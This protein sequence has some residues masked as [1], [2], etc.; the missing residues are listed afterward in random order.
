MRTDPAPKARTK[1]A[2]ERR[3]DLMNAA[4][5]TFLEKG[6]EQATVEEITQGADVAKG[7][8][9]LHFSSKGDILQALRERFVQNMLGRIVEA[10]AAR[11]EQDWRGRL[12][13]WC[14]ACAMA[15][16]ETTRLHH[17]VFI[18]VP[19]SREGLTRNSIIDHLADLL[20]AGAR[21]KAWVV[22]DPYFTA[23]FLFNA[24]HGVVNQPIAA[25]AGIG[26]DRLLQAIDVHFRRLFALPAASAST[27]KK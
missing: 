18:A 1:P 11:E 8:F 23:V 10:V 13:A 17:L 26:R 4:E 5:R 2:A 9:Y 24:L 21:A 27:T 19:P 20:A 16:L 6:F 14:R 3:D 25:E 12:S 7:T 22:E 15:Y